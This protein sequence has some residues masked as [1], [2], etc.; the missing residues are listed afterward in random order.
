MPSRRLS[1]LRWRRIARPPHSPGQRPNGTRTAMSSPVSVLEQ[2]TELKHLVRSHEQHA[3]EIKAIKATAA[4][5]GCHGRSTMASR[6]SDRVAAR[7]DG[8]AARADARADRASA[9]SAARSS[10]GCHGGAPA[11]SA[12]NGCHGGGPA[13]AAAAACD[14]GCD[15]GD[16]RGC[17]GCSADCASRR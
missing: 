15:C 3:A 2:Y 12:S 6:R 13:P 10:G 11:R 9:R 4:A 14:C 7:A 16:A 1:R 8:R 17:D 5:E